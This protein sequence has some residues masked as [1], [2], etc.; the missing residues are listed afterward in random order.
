MGVEKIT[1]K[2]PSA[3]FLKGQTPYI[4]VDR[5][6]KEII[7]SPYNELPEFYTSLNLKGNDILLAVNDV[8]YSFENIYDMINASTKWKEYDLITIKIKR[9]GIEQIL[10]GNVKI[11]LE[12]VEGLKATDI[13]KNK[14][15]E[16]WLKG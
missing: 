7:I 3:I 14:I 13:S 9:D 10:K 11:P 4:N 2:K 1:L 16:A 12:D 6:T 15:K 8:P 5:K